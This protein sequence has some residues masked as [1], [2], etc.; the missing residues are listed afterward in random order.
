MGNDHSHPSSLTD[1]AF[2]ALL[3]SELKLDVKPTDTRLYTDAVKACIVDLLAKDRTALFTE[4]IKTAPLQKDI[5]GDFVLPDPDPQLEELAVRLLELFPDTL[6]AVRF[7]LVPVKVKE[8]EF[9]A[10][11]WVLARQSVVLNLDRKIAAL[12]ELRGGHT[13]GVWQTNGHVIGKS[14]W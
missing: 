1:D 14:A 4:A 10:R 8:A 2:L 5:N 11:F 12:K 6:G 7:H 13:G 9:W 3:P